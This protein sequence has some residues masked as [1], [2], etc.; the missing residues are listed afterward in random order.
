V[1]EA[2]EVPDA[3]EV[4][5]PLSAPEPTP[6]D[7]GEPAAGAVPDLSSETDKAAEPSGMRPLQASAEAEA[8]ARAA[9][10]A[11]VEKTLTD[12]GAPGRLAGQVF[13]A[14]GPQAAE[15]L[16]GDPWNLLAVPGLS[17][18][19]ADLF[20]RGVLGSTPDDDPRRVGAVIVWQLQRSAQDGHTAVDASTVLSVLS[21]F[22][23]GDPDAALGLAVSEGRVMAFTE[24]DEE[25]EFF[26]E[27]SEEEVPEE[28]AEPPR[29]LIALDRYAL[30]EESL[31]EAVV[32]LTAT[33]EPSPELDTALEGTNFRRGMARSGVLLYASAPLEDPPTAVLEAAARA[34]GAG[35]RVVTATPT[36]DGRD[37]LVHA[38]HPAT[39]LRELL[40]S[41]DVE[42]DADGTLALDL[43]VVTDATLLDVEAA[44]ALFEAVPD[45]ARLLLAGDPA[46]LE[47]TGPGRVFGDL[48]D[49]AATG[50]VPLVLSESEPPGVLGTLATGVRDGALPPVDDPEKQV[51]LV[52]ARSGDEAV[53]R[54]VQLVADSIPRALGIPAAEILVITPAYGGTAGT[55]ALNTALK[56]RLNPG[57]GRYGGFDTGD[58]VVRVPPVPGTGLL[59]GVVEEALEDGL[60]VAFRDGTSVVVPRERL[61]SLR[62]GW[63]VTAHHTTGVRR[64]GVVAVLPGEAAGLLTRPLVYTAFTRAE[65]HLSIVHA[66]GPALGWA[67]GNV[68]ERPRTTRLVRAVGEAAG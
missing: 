4:D 15:L 10:V 45:G 55:V 47:S 60:R 41:P 2:P 44:A 63:A 46:G 12:G 21:H 25:E 11:E 59:D 42:R 29:V 17:P 53:H 23:V 30:A 50:M 62:H 68:P 3:P 13:S 40:T 18:Q 14:L 58:R 31:A 51:V 22:G 67:V 26:E 65:R 37:R 19:Q 8:E 66:A 49:I 27:E 34:T 57:Q 5:K 32:R 9:A 52:Q 38:G 35:L 28:P 33:L 16:R 39:T 43:L 36:V 1:P 6:E 61:G 48:I 64:P 24:G 56:A 20:A 54:A 7:T